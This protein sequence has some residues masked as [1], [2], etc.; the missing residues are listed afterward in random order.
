MKKR[1]IFAVLAL[2]IVTGAGGFWL[3]NREQE[4]RLDVISRKD[5]L[6]DYD[7][8]WETLEENYPFFGV[9]E[10]KY[11]LDVQQLKQEYRQQ[12]E[13]MG[14]EIDFLEFYQLMEECIGQ[15]RNLG[16]IFLYPSN[17][18]FEDKKEIV[19]VMQ[20]MNQTS[21]PLLENRVDIYTN[22]EV[23]QRYEFLQQH[24]GEESN[25]T[26]EH[27]GEMS[28]NLILERKNDKILY[29][30]IKSFAGEYLGEESQ[31]EIA[32]FLQ[33]NAD[34]P[35]L[36]IDVCGNPGGYTNY[37]SDYI[38]APNISESICALYFCVTPYGEN[39]EKWLKIDERDQSQ[40]KNQ[41]DE[42]YQ[43]PKINIDD[44]KNIR[45]YDKDK[46][47]ISPNRHE[48]LYK[49]QIFL[50]IDSGTCSA[51]DSFAYFCKQ[52]GFATVLGQE[53]TH[54]SGPGGN[55][56]MDRLPHSNLLFRYR[57]VLALD[58][59]GAALEEF[60]VAP[61]VLLPSRAKNSNDKISAL[62][63]CL[64]YIEGLENNE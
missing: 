61:D 28:S 47:C 19:H 49:G 13:G 29:M 42:L 38:V 39:S 45:Y 35:Y 63:A 20:A 22:P 33:Q 27:S 56:A 60:G 51:A 43:L 6:E 36:V 24:S 57:P 7:Y 15:F 16:H 4:P 18:Y 54:G 8:L 9:A 31:K 41:L 1:F 10:R 48:R 64:S 40:L 14:K 32:E 44:L 23:Q 17:L 55:F 34:T 59:D 37:W 5:A 12:L 21:N 53:N 50:L 62:A 25:R 26:L 3:L 11:G 52:T 2:F 46:Y 58:M 30:K